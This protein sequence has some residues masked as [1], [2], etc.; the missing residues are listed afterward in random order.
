M[1]V[2]LSV[3]TSSFNDGILVVSVALIILHLLLDQPVGGF[4]TVGEGIISMEGLG[5]L[6]SSP[7]SQLEEKH[8]QCV[9]PHL[10]QYSQYLS[11]KDVSCFTSPSKSVWVITVVW[12]VKISGGYPNSWL[13][14]MSVLEVLSS[15]C[16]LAASWG[17]LPFFNFTWH[18]WAFSHV[19]YFSILV[20]VFWTMANFP[21]VV[22]IL[23]STSMVPSGIL[24]NRYSFR[25]QAAL[26][27]L[28]NAILKWK[29][30]NKI[31]QVWVK[32]VK[33]R[34]T[35]IALGVCFWSECYPCSHSR[36]Y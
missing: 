34:L 27:D 1:L 3:L 20:W 31:A 22:L 12:S 15:V 24:Q 6:T 17:V 21:Y 28:R 11:E 33:E 26:S 2:P 10:L 23:T 18:L 30:Q 9:S 35:S 25:S 29:C 7:S 8:Q 14:G 4:L 32:M 13:V 19:W 36:L 16:T 5:L